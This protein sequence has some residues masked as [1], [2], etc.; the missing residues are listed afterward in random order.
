[1]REDDGVTPVPRTRS[2]GHHTT[3]V[4]VRAFTAQKRAAMAAHASQI[5]ES[6]FFLQL[7]EDAFLASFGQEWFIRDGAPR[8]RSETWLLDGA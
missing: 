3:V 8:D 2:C 5:A 1:M 4:D 7:P 6:S